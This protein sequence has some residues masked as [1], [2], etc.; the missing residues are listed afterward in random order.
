MFWFS[1]WNKEQCEQ[2][3][4]AKFD[5]DVDSFNGNGSYNLFIYRRQPSKKERR[6][7]KIN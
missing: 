5:D 1:E 3:V 2:R 4:Y 6:R 7:I